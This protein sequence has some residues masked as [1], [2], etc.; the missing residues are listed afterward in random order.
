ML[1][2]IGKSVVQKYSHSF[3]T[4]TLLL[5]AGSVLAAQLIVWGVWRAERNSQSVIALKEVATNMAMRV[6]AT[7][8]Y[9]N[10]LPSEYRHIVLDQLREMRG[11]TYF[12]TLNREYIDV[13]ALPMNKDMRLVADSFTEILKED[14]SLPNHLDIRFANP[15]KLHVFNNKTL[16]KDLPNYWD[17]HTQLLRPGN[18]DVLV[19][20]IPI[21]EGEW[22]YIAT[23]APN[24]L[25]SGGMA[26]ESQILNFFGGGMLILLLLLT[27]L[28][29]R[30]II[31]PF[32]NLAKA[33]S[34]FGR[35][36]TP[37]PLPEKGSTE[38]IEAIHAFNQ[39]Q[40]N[41]RQS[42]NDRKAL[43]SGISHDLKTPLTRLRLR[44]AMMDDCEERDAIEQ[45][46]DYLDLMVKSALQTV[47]E[48]D[49]H[50]NAT[51]IRLDHLIA[52]IAVSYPQASLISF[53]F[54]KT[55]ILPEI[56][57][58]PL[59][60]RRC[61]ENLIDNAIRY[62]QRADVSLTGSSGCWV[63]RIYDDGP[64]IPEGMEQD[65]FKAN[66]R[67]PYGKQRNPN[68]SGLGLMAARH[69]ARTHGGD[70]VIER[71]QGEGVAK[72]KHSF[73]LTLP[74][75]TSPAPQGFT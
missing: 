62:G 70:L 32:S 71:A 45:D 38:V 52:D 57:G 29:V 54:Q 28:K 42:M 16:L 5:V 19:L 63:I 51:H 60:L 9:F 47:R 26:Q 36:L 6:S 73:K 21:S 75:Q 30:E 24:Y 7:V 50:E 12:V 44:V 23:I 72:G 20:Q 55:H 37:V 34:S 56:I 69:M 10:S 3:M 15:R 61:L 17:T 35:N 8:E 53:R 64:G 4:R 11:G 74:A 66:F 41:V 2:N 33:A 68:G 49:V 39:M 22:L 65:I 43:F 1:R 14:T 67:L 40:A 13:E 46:L 27:V 25:R 48:T 31:R 18:P 58:R 59:A